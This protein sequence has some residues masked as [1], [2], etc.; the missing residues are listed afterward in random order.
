MNAANYYPQK[1]RIDIIG[2][3]NL[4]IGGFMGV[5]AHIK[6]LKLVSQGKTITLIIDSKVNQKTT[7]AN[8]NF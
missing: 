2:Q 8:K 5:Q 7:I 6:A 1:N 3:D 4:P